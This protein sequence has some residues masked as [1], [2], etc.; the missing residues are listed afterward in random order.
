MSYGFDGKIEDFRRKARLLAGGQVTEP[1]STMTYV[2]VV[3]RDT[4]RI[5]LTLDALNYLPAKVVDIQNA[6]II[7]PVTDKIWTVLG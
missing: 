6:Y 1:P 5:A 2:I 7:A 3:S 4:L